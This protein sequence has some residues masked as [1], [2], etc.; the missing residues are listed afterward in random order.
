MPLGNWNLQW[1]NHNSQRSYPL[2]ERATKVDVTET[3]KLPDNFI[4]GLYFP[5]HAGVTFRP[6][7]FFIKNVLI[8]PTG[9]NITLGYADGTSTVE[10]A[11][12]NIVRSNYAPNRSYALGGVDDFND[13]VGYVVLGTL[14]DVDTLPPGLY[15]F[16][17]AGGMLEPDA[18]RPMIR[19]ISRLQVASGTEISAP[20]YGDVTLVAGNNVRIDVQQFADRTEIIFNAI[21]GVNLNQDCLCNVPPPGECIRCINGVCSEDGTFT[22]A[23]DDCI[24]LVPAGTGLSIRDTCATPC[25]G[26]TELDALTTQLSLLGTG[27]TTLQNFVSRLGAEVSQ[28]SLTVLGSRF[29]NSGCSPCADSEG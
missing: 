2:T 12:A 6:E 8:A 20:I 3:I 21:A 13:S 16:D 11:S 14:A 24:E 23:Q 15:T 26:C 7:N 29:N 10:V 1:L 22:I 27:V 18:I 4:V 25:C 28:M 19:G 5:I 9:F 17:Y